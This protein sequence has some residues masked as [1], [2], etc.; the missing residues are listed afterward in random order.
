MTTATPIIITEQQLD[1]G[2]AAWFGLTQV[3]PERTILRDRMHAAIIAAGAAPAAP[4]SNFQRVAAMNTA[5]G[6]PEGQPTAIDWD[7]VRK[8]SLNIVH[9]FGELMV[10]LGADPTAVKAAIQRLDWVATKPVN[11]I[12]AI[13][14][15]DALCDIHVFA[16]GSHHF[17]GIDAD[18]DVA[19]VVDGVMTRFIKN[20]ADKAATIAKH[21][22]A[23]VTDVYFEGEYPTMVMKSASDQPD[24]PKGKFLKSASY[25]EPVFAALPLQQE[26][27]AA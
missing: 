25:N 11:P 3:M 23:G 24:A 1:A 26:G 2:L 13:G 16:Y 10:A 5:F 9:E 8:Q 12:N 19:V 7:R 4:R 18:V 6:N 27:G 20:D 21:A 14:A 15:R 17:M 22:A